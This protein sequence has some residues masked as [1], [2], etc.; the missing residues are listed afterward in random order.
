[1]AWVLDIE[2]VGQPV[3]DIP[4]RALQYL[5][6]SL[7]RDRPEP[8]ELEA[9]KA[10]LIDRFGLDPTTGR[11]IVIGLVE[12]ETGVERSFAE[13]SEKKLLTA[14]WDWLAEEKPSLVVTFN[15]KR[16]DIPYLNVRSA[17]HGLMPRVVIPMERFT[18]HPHFDVREVLVGNERH[19]RGGLD[20]FCAI[21][22]IDSPKAE[23][24][25]SQV[26]GAYAEDRI[27]E[28]TR[29]CLADCRATAALYRR[30]RPFWGQSLTL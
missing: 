2:T 24:D 22:G 3:E 27:E 29:Y 4:E 30:L 20:Y 14:F 16:F 21:F 17:I 5:Y 10:E 19:R 28:I 1:M 6:R 26:A 8:K 12:S 11:V 25:G 18:T 15:G 7:E 9:R 13:P 23:L